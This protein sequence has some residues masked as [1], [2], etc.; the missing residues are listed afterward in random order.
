MLESLDILSIIANPISFKLFKDF[1]E[2][3]CHLRNFALLYKEKFTN[4][5]GF[6]IYTV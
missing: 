3:K 2:S 4:F 1:I 6:V 5:L